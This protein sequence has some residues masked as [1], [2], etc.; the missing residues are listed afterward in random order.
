MSIEPAPGFDRGSIPACYGGAS[1]G[2]CLF[3]ILCRSC[4]VQK[5]VEFHQNV[6]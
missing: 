3:A 2:H 4:V 5:G 6:G 1:S